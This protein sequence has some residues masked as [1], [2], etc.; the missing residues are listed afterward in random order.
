MNKHFIHAGQTINVLCSSNLDEV[1]VVL[2][3]QEKHQLIFYAPPAYEA[4]RLY[5][6]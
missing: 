1:L 4:A 5:L 2:L 6:C 3:F